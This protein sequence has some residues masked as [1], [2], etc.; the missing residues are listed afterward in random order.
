M[1]G[2]RAFWIACRDDAMA[3]IL[4]AGA[5]G[6]VL[7]VVIVVGGP[8]YRVGSHRQFLLLARRLAAAGYP[9]LRFDYRGMG[10]SSGASRDFEHVDEDIRAAVD[11]LVA[12]SGVA[13]VALWG[14]CDGASAALMYAATDPRVAGVIG[15]NPWV[16]SAQGEAQARIRGYYLERLA[17]REFWG[18]VL[19]FE[20]DWRESL[21]SLFGYARAAAGRRD[22]SGGTQSF[23]ARMEQGLA[24]F[25]GRFHVAL[26][27]NDFTA[28]E[29]RLLLKSSSAW[30][31]LAARKI[32]LAELPGANHTFASREW[33]G[34]V[35]ER[36]LDW[37]QEI[38]AG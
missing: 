38:A 22:E 29:F 1:S 16:H 7:G 10:D 9:V 17:N 13:R 25:G 34:W 2:E 26:S 31:G 28:D 14:L 23:L 11:A 15:L 33:R 36:T 8:Q 32:T 30:S 37:L 19:R 6:A 24:R 18:K 20:F 27:G 12:A 35:E 21:R 3:A 5:A 4:H